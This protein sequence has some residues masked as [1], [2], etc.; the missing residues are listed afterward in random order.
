MRSK[1][2]SAS[3]L[4]ERFESSRVRESRVRAVVR[5]S[6]AHYTKARVSRRDTKSVRLRLREVRESRRALENFYK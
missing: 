4:Y 6:M 3:A 5:R 1:F 2:M